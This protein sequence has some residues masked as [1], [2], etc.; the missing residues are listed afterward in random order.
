MCDM[1]VI[2]VCEKARKS[3]RKRE[4]KKDSVCVREERGCVLVSGVAALT[5]QVIYLKKKKKKQKQYKKKK[6]ERKKRMKEKETNQQ[7]QTQTNNLIMALVFIFEE[8]FDIGHVV[9]VDALSALA[10][11]AHRDEARGH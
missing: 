6:I 8:F 5:T 2:C 9:A 4:S 10:G 7:T 3:E 1:C 11:E